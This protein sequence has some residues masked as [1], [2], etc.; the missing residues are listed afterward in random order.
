VSVLASSLRGARRWFWL[1]ASALVVLAQAGCSTQPYSLYTDNQRGLGAPPIESGATVILDVVTVEAPD[2]P[3]R[4]RYGDGRELPPES[5]ASPEAIKA[6]LE[7]LQN[8]AEKQAAADAFAAE[9]AA[10][11][12]KNV[13]DSLKW[14]GYRVV[15]PGEDDFRARIKLR[16][17]ASSKVQRKTVEKDV[18]ERRKTGTMSGYCY[19]TM[20]GLMQCSYSEDTYLKKLGTKPVEVGTRMTSLRLQWF[21]DGELIHTTALST[22]KDYCV[23]QR[24]L[25]IL[26]S[27][28]LK[29]SLKRTSSG[30]ITVRLPSGYCG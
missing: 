24:R 12:R 4:M 20:F 21:R 2:E 3:D 11:V 9:Q 7:S 19:E 14:L 23:L 16:V 30:N 8:I 17:V 29:Q 26:S 1:S 22:D 25:E 6:L 5:V 28:G 18:Y 27:E 10:L 13:T 15:K